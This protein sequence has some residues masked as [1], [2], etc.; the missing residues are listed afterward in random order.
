MASPLRTS[1][2][3]Q[4]AVP[5]FGT[6]TEVVK[7][8]PF[9]SA[10]PV[11]VV[12]DPPV[13]TLDVP[14]QLLEI[15][16]LA[17]GVA[18]DF[19]NILQVI[20]GNAESL[21]AS[22]A[23]SDP[24]HAAATAIVEAAGRASTMTR[25]LQTIG[26]RQPSAPSS[27][28]V[29][30]LV[31]EALPG[32]RRHCHQQVRLVTH[33]TARIPHIC[34]DRV[35]IQQI[36]SDLV[37]HACEAMT[38]GGTLTLVTDVLY[39]GPQMQRTRPWLRSGRY[40]RLEVA[41]SGS[42]LDPQSLAHLFEPFYLSPSR[43]GQGLQLAAVYSLV[44]QSNGFIWADSDVGQGSRVTVLF[45]ATATSTAA[46]GQT[47]ARGRVLLV[48]DDDSVRELLD[49]VLMHH[50]YSVASYGNAEDALDHQDPFDLLL[51]DVVLPGMDGPGLAREIQ[52]R[53]PALPVLLMS[54]DAGHADDADELEPRG[55]LHKP[56]SSQTLISSVEQLLA[57]W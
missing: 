28:D 3:V 9:R 12:E 29:S 49:G 4:A 35:Q 8:V 21:M 7:A 22:L 54:G 56:F 18:N 44:K 48:E 32:L 16:R 1:V 31:S 13:V 5:P 37:V 27:F 40:V 30:S 15:W 36:L 50:G 47:R 51:T 23:P 2:K 53:V 26:R 25:Q 46:E 19:N 14:P 42:G 39:V 33:L 41:D 45:P 52:R 34:G 11:R 10:R 17:N 20:G 43:A 38:H 57:G 6:I 55:F 24:R